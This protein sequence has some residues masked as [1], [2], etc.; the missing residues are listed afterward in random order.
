MERAQ[1]GWYPDKRVGARQW[2][3]LDK[4]S[5]RNAVFTV[6]VP[7]T[8]REAGFGCRIHTGVMTHHVAFASVD[9][10]EIYGSSHD[11]AKDRVCARAVRQA[12]DVIELGDGE[13]FAERTRD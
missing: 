13:S 12:P 10:Q 4:I 9:P 5:D 11:N 7:D 3:R 8:R 1:R 2:H 6:G